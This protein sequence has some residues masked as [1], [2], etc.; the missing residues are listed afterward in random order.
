MR[1]RPLILSAA[2]LF[3]CTAYPDGSGETADSFAPTS[4]A[5]TG[6]SQESPPPQVEVTCA[7]SST[8]VEVGEGNAETVQLTAEAADD[9]GPISTD[10]LQWRMASGPGSVSASGLYTTAVDHGGLARIEASLHDGSDLCEV[11]VRAHAELNPSGEAAAPGAFAAETPT[12]DDACAASFVYP[13]DDAAMPGGFAPPRIQWDPAGSNLHKLVLSSEWT[14]LE[15]VTSEDHHEPSPAQ[16]SG[17]TRFDP[18]TR[19]EMKLTSGTWSGAGFTGGTC[20]SSSPLEIEVTNEAMEGTIVYWALAGATG[21]TRSLSFHSASAPT[22]ETVSLPGSGCE[23]CHTV[24]LERP[25]R[26]T[27]GTDNAAVTHLV[28]LAN[29]STVLQSWGADMTGGTIGLE[30][31][32]YGAPDPTGEYVLLSG[33][34]IGLTGP[35]EDMVL[36]RQGSGAEVTTVSTQR[37]ATMP[38]WSPDGTRI[39]YAGCAGGGSAMHADDCSLYVQTWDPASETFGG[40]TRIAEPP[41]GHTLYY[42]SFSPDSEW[43]AFNQA[44]M[45]TDGDDLVTS[46]ANP[47]AKVMLVSASGGTPRFL[48]HANATGDL[49]NSWPRW[50]PDTGEH[51]WLAYSTERPYGHV[52]SGR[53]QL[54]VSAIDLDAAAAGSADPSRPPVWIPG[55]RTGDRNYTPTWLPRL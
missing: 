43:V 53:A 9:E 46:Y 42:P 15:I 1:A 41:A 48:A 10:G 54:W 23:G 14:T 24:N 26:M 25:T 4:E 49:T 17:L 44:E 5:D 39:V 33:F 32:D 30:R 6:P 7:P 16:W 35:V 36:F 31:R 38:N 29:P 8:Q 3:G 45:W 2:F 11:E 50:A 28:D 51:A 47:R 27:Y 18:G 37:T 22:N 52:V 55:Q 20:T 13:L 19:V 21:L 34:E 12:V 40:E